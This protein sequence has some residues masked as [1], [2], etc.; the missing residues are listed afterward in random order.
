MLGSFTLEPS[1]TMVLQ[2]NVSPGQWF[3]RTRTRSSIRCADTANV[4]N[5]T[6]QRVRTGERMTPP[7]LF[8][9]QRP[10]CRTSN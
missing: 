2:R 7:T 8:T 6:V 5:P 10:Y 3:T 4:V 9:P 1:I